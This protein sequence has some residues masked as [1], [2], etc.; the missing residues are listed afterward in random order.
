M[1]LRERAGALERDRH[2]APW[3]EPHRWPEVAEVAAAWD[4]HRLLAYER[5]SGVRAV[6]A[7][8]AAGY[9]VD[10]LVRVSRAVQRSQFAERQRAEGKRLGLSSLTPEIVRRELESGQNEPI[11]LV[12]KVKLDRARARRE[13]SNAG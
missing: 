3:V 12:E 1:P 7:L 8:F 6:V 10:E 11:G 2:L 13:A 4:A 5:D 9:S